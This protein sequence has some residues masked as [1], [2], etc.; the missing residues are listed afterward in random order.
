[1]SRKSSSAKS[2]SGVSRSNETSLS[3]AASSVAV[4]SSAKSFI[5]SSPVVAGSGSRPCACATRSSSTNSALSAF[6]C[7]SVISWSS[8]AA[9]DMASSE[10]VLAGGLVTEA[11]CKSF[12]STSCCSISEIGESVSD[13]VAAAIFSADSDSCLARF[14]TSGFS[15]ISSSSA[16]PRISRPSSKGF[17]CTF[18][19]GCKLGFSTT[20][21]GAA[22]GF[23]RASDLVSTA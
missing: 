16:R 12:A 4:S 1:M 2:I 23:S 19:L 7:S 3:N 9:S 11:A 6:S 15:P 5:C 17:S 18:S 20:E 22:S 13:R 14:I 8:S 21:T 10:G